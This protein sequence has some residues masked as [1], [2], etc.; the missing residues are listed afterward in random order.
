VRHDSR[1]E[2]ILALP[3]RD[4][5]SEIVGPMVV[6]IVNLFTKNT[7]LRTTRDFLLPKL[8]SG[9]IPIEAAAEFVEQAV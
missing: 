1:C 3:L 4:R 9:E 5:V 6:E 8:I 7:N 2:V